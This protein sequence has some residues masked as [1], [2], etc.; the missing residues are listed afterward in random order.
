MKLPSIGLPWLVGAVVF[1]PAALLIA[2][3]TADTTSLFTKTDVMVPMRDGVKLHTVIFAPRG[4]RE[5]LPILLERTPYGARDDERGLRERYWHLIPDGFIFAFQDIRGRFKS[6]G[7]F[8]MVRPV[9]DKSDPKAI[10]KGTD[11]YDTISWLLE[12]TTG[13][14]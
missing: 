7:Q 13:P 4:A 5:P 1:C 6:E 2:Q 3:D 8:V 11:A 9:R 12:T 10:E 14:H